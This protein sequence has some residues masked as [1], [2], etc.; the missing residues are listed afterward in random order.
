MFINI[1]LKYTQK[2]D[3]HSYT[4]QLKQAQNYNDNFGAL[5]AN[6]KTRSCLKGHVWQCCTFRTFCDSVLTVYTIR[7]CHTYIRI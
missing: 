7:P 6:A 1:E 4:S 3:F 2:N 5:L